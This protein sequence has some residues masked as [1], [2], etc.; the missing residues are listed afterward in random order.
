MGHIKNAI[1]LNDKDNG[2]GMYVPLVK[3]MK[4]WWKYQC[5]LR[6]P[7]IERPKPKGFW[8]ECLTAENFDQNQESYADHFISVLE[9]VSERYS[10]VTDV[11]EL[12]DPGLRGGETIKTSMSLDEFQVFMEAV[13]EGLDL[14][15]Q[16]EAEEDEEKSTEIWRGIFGDEFPCAAAKKEAGT[17]IGVYRDSGEEFLS[18]FGIRENLAYDLKLNARGSENGFRPFYLLDLARVLLENIKNENALDYFTYCKKAL[19][20]VNLAKYNNVNKKILIESVF[21]RH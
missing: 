3:L 17:K 18:D 1:T 19:S 4:Y 7:D 16:A 21:L 9:N 10:D 8:V 12:E 5:G 20:Y 2:N 6:Q 13:N 15:Y 11:P 14:A